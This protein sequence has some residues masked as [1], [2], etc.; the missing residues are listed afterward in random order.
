[1]TAGWDVRAEMKI[2]ENDPK[3]EAA[4]TYSEL[5]LRCPVSRVHVDGARYIGGVR[6]VMMS[7]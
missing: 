7:L 4:D 5:L 1:M 6:S 2:M 3:V